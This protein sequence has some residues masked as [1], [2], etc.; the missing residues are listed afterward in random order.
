MTAEAKRMLLIGYGNPARMDDG[1]GIALTKKIEALA[2]PGLTIESDYQLSVEDAL[3]I[4]QYDRVVIADATLDKD[5]K[6]FSFQ[7]ILPDKKANIPFSSHSVDP[8]QLVTLASTMF[9]TK[10]EVYLLGIRGYEFEMF[11]EQMTDKAK[12]NLD[13]A[14][15]FLEKVFRSGKFSEVIK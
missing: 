12:Q 7:R 8:K 6:S 13:K 3:M 11:Q 15:Q 4:S 9:K 1:L 5:I 2:I 14:A 10:T